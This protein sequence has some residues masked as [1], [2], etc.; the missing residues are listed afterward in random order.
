MDA[1]NLG[2]RVLSVGDE[3]LQTVGPLAGYFSKMTEPLS[4]REAMDSIFKACSAGEVL[5]GDESVLRT[6]LEVSMEYAI[7][8]KDILCVPTALT[9]NEIGAIAL[10]T[11]PYEPWQVAFYNVLNTALRSEDRVAIKPFIHVIWLLMH[12]LKKSEPYS[13]SVLFRG[14]KKD[15]SA[16]YLKGRRFSWYSVSSCSCMAEVLENPLFLGN[17]GERTIFSIELHKEQNRA[18][19]IKQFSLVKSEDE[20]ILPPNSRFEVIS[21][22]RA[23]SGLV[24]IHLKELPSMDPI[25]PFDPNPDVP[26]VLPALTATVASTTPSKAHSQTTATTLPQISKQAQLPADSGTVSAKLSASVTGPLSTAGASDSRPLSEL[27]M[28]EVGGLLSA[29]SLGK[30]VEAFKRNEVDGATL[31]SCRKEL[32]IKELG[33]AMHTKAN[34]LWAKVQEFQTNGVPVALIPDIPDIPDDACE[35][36]QEAHTDVLEQLADSLVHK[37]PGVRGL[38]AA[39]QNKAH[40]EATAH[41]DA[42]KPEAPLDPWMLPESC[43]RFGY[44][45]GPIRVWQGRNKVLGPK[46]HN[47]RCTAN[48]AQ[49][50][51]ADKVSFWRVDMKGS[52]LDTFVGIIGNDSPS[53]ES[54][55]DPT[56]FGWGAMGEVIIGGKETEMRGEWGGM[57]E[58][59]ILVFKFDPLSRFGASLSVSVKNK[60]HFISIPSGHLPFTANVYLFS[61]DSVIVLKAATSECMA[62]F[63]H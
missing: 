2:S 37:K 12:A 39:K 20:I 29:L 4:L 10:Y 47:F 15:L 36:V 44:T 19:S 6:M 46:K 43:L 27:S 35:L 62:L 5:H 41:K 9:V 30:Y 54:Y 11:M 13:G 21:H 60:L 3:T 1:K 40:K 58:G 45:S 31:A 52:A 42:R 26:H 50:L 61:C 56:F 14:V 16:M 57:T 25:L 53:D 34:L 63:P 23:G 59:D 18:R 55:R 38:R 8:Q 22:L 32:D 51:P 28:A 48:A 24:I 49:P 17:S 7:N 33:V